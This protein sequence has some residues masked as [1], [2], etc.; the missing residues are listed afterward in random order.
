MKGNI[1]PF[2]SIGLRFA[3]V[4][5]ESKVEGAIRMRIRENLCSLSPMERADTLLRKFYGEQIGLFLGLLVTVFGMWICFL[6]FGGE[7]KTITIG[8]GMGVSLK[9]ENAFFLL[10]ALWALL[11]ARRK[12]AIDKAMKERE[13]QMRMD[14]PKI[15]SKLTMLFSAGLTIR[16]S[17]EKI[18]VA[19]IRQREAGKKVRYAYEEMLLAYR[20]LQGGMSEGEVYNRFG[21]RCKLAGYMKLSALLVQNLKKGNKGLGE[22]LAYEGVQA[23]EERKSLAK[24]LGEEGATKLLLP[25][26]LMLAIVIVILIVP[27]F[28]TLQF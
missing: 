6:V 3:D 13:K 5:M 28:M 24:K 4:F 14:Y 27:A 20:E 2:Y 18:V 15:V 21:R 17:W 11:F 25:M 19:Y 1:R 23:M 7:S 22:L 8:G 10:L 12:S 26:L 16:E 9:M